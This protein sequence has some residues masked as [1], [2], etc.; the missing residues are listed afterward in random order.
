MEQVRLGRPLGRLVPEV[1]RV[2]EQQKVE[3]CKQL[4]EEKPSVECDTVT[5]TSP[6]LLT[7]AENPVT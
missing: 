5:V 6:V 7:V 1:C 4:G 2:E 3:V